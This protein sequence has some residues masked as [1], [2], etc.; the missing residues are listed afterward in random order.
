MNKDFI[1][2]EDKIRRCDLNIS[3]MNVFEY[4][5]CHIFYWGYFKEI[6]DNISENL[7]EFLK[8]GFALIYV[9]IFLIFTPLTLTLAAII[10]IKRSK[11]WVKFAETECD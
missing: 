10:H 1:K 7:I 8:H 9:L 5:Y 2:D 4:I 11:K 3:K 6:Y